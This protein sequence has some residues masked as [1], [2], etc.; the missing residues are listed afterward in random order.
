MFPITIGMLLLFAVLPARW[1]AWVHP[2]SQLIVI[3]TAPVADLA[4]HVVHVFLPAA[5][6]TTDE[7]ASL[8]Q[9]EIEGYKSLFLRERSENDR[10][11]SLIQ[12][13]Q[14]GLA[15]N[16]NLPVR[17]IA[18]PVIG[19]SSDLSSGVL[20]VRLLQGG[21]ADNNTVATTTGLQLVG[22]VVSS[23]GPVCLLQPITSKS[24][25]KLRVTIDAGKGQLL[26]LAANLQPTG[27]GRLKGDVF[28]LA[29]RTATGDPIPEPLP[30]QLVRLD[31][32]DWPGTAQMLIVGVI[33]SVD[34]A[35]DQLLR[36]VITVRPTVDVTRVAEVV[37]RLNDDAA[38]SGGSTTR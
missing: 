6:K 17:L 2:L 27:D 18:A 10:L 35:P 26:P 7:Q 3:P 38:P 12:Q 21:R 9:E 15:L 20:R 23:T 32:S 13:L 14:S 16:P 22:R 29:E 37:L 33:E 5:P 11:R 4:A 8:M 1:L 24:A 28:V 34:A 25:G 30:G 36:S 31:D 19:T